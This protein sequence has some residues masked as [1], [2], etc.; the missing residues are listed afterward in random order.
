ML[1]K[2]FTVCKKRKHIYNS[3][4]LMVTKNYLFSEEW[5]DSRFNGSASQFAVRVFR[6]ETGSH[7]DLVPDFE[8]SLQDRASGNATF[9]VVNL[10]TGLVDVEWPAND[11]I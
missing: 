10:R 8:N 2:I 5:N 3:I 9:Q 11:K 7:L 1:F 4:Q 6:D